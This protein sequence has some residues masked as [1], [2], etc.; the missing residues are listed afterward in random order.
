M[1][2]Q[3]LLEEQFEYTQNLFLLE[4][5]NSEDEIL[6]KVKE[7]VPSFKAAKESGNEQEYQA[8]ANQISDLL[9]DYFAAEA[10]EIVEELEGS[11]RIKTTQHNYGRYGA[12]ISQ[13]QGLYR[14][15][16]VKAL[17][18]AGAGPGL[19]WAVKLF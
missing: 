18:R 19:D 3:E 8:L 10:K 5:E 1:K 6:L 13:Y 11:K 9:A 14:V 17:K 15:G 2:D 7:L 16:L 4:N 12:F